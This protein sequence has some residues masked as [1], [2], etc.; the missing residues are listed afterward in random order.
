MKITKS[1]VLLVC[2]VMMGSLVFAAGQGVHEPGTG[3]EDPDLKEANQ[4]SGQ[5]LNED[6]VNQG[7]DA[8]A[9]TATPPKR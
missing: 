2:L 5:S 4:G 7:Q 8:Q 1:I 9:N 6:S 3:I